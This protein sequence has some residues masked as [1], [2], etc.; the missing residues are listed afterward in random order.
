MP[1]SS[2][3]ACRP[4]ACT[5][6][7]APPAMVRRPVEVG[8]AGQRAQQHVMALARHQRADREDGARRAR[9][10]PARAAPGRC[11]ARRRRCGRGGRRI[12]RRAARAVCGEVAMSRARRG[13]RSRSI[14]AQRRAVL[15]RCAVFQRGRVVD[16]ADGAAAAE[17]VGQRRE[18]GQAEAVD[19]RPRVRRAARPARARA[20]ASAASSGSGWRPASSTTWTSWPSARRPSAI[21]GRRCSRRRRCRRGRGRAAPASCVR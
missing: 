7:R 10:S 2:A 17:V 1:S 9:P 14:A 4:C 15:R 18:G 20:A 21:R 11:P 8:Q 5:G 3:S 6:S 19:H 12:R 13:K 16:Q